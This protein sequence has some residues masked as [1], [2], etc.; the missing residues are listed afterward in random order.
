MPSVVGIDFGTSN[1]SIAVFMDGRPQVIPNQEGRAL[2][3]TVVA[4]TRGGELLVGERAKVFAMQE[5]AR[6]LRSFKRHLG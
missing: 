3:P 6:T 2:T 5:P 1:S 4:L